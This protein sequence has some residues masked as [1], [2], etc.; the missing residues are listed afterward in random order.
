MQKSC[1]NCGSSFPLPPQ[2]QE[3]YRTLDVLNPVECPDCRRQRRL[4]FRNFFHLYHRTCDLTGK[5]II[6]MYDEDA[7][8]PVYGIQEWWSDRWDGLQ[9]GV[10]PDFS[11]PFFGQMT[12]LHHIVPR[13]CF[14]NV[15][16]ENCDYCNMSNGSRNCYLVFGNVGNED[17]MYGHIVWQSQNCYDCLYTY[18]SAFCYECIDCVQCHTLSFSRDC[19]NCTSSM[20][21][22]HCVGCSD[23]FG[24][25]GLKNKQNHIFNV[26]HSKEEYAKKIDALNT[27]NIRTVSLAKERVQMLIGKEIVKHY[28][29]FNCEN[30]TGDYLYNC[31][32]VIE[33]Y[34]LKNCE[35]C[36]YS[37][38]LDSFTDS[39]DCN[40]CGIN[41]GKHAELCYNCLT[42][43]PNYRMFCCHASQ[44]DNANLFYCDT[45][46]GCQDC[47]G[48]ISLK[49]KRYC[50]LNKQYTKEE[51]ET[52]VPKIIEHMKKTPY[53]TPGG[54]G[55]G[56]AGEWGQ[57]FPRELSPFGYNE[58]IAQV[59]FPLEKE[60]IHEKGWRWKEEQPDELQQNYLGTQVAIPDDIRAVPDAICNQILRCE[61]SGRLYKIIPQELKFYQQMNLPLPRKCFMQRQK[62]RFALRNPR[63]LWQRRCGKCGK[64]IQTSYAPERPETVYCEECYLKEVY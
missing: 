56:Q 26:P 54:V 41:V 55:T 29:G 24:C 23:C 7:T 14:M 35:D 63:K 59:Y 42:V 30:V 39:M 52:L 44:N 46:H 38:T 10:D 53:Q 60:Q 20:F 45:C 61:G 47:F 6:S 33:G 9:Y 12:V 49:K 17:C 31:K 64:E 5:K 21:L 40:F 32:N 25:V 36:L 13:I 27:G 19:D 51:Y 57:F 15:N 58:T 4:M 2:E 16:C 22:V 50:I 3:L 1:T 43:G 28:H 48:C 34:D 62:E 11:R 37:A 8:F 18:R